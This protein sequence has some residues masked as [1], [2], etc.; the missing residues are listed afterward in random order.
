MA[1]KRKR[2]A[3]QPSTSAAPR[4]KL[5]RLAK[6]NNVTAAQ[7]EEIREAFSLYKVDHKDYADSAE[8]VLETKNVRHCLTALGVKIPRGE[9]PEVLETLDPEDEGVVGFENFFAFAAIH[10][11]RHHGEDSDENYGEE[12]ED[13]EQREEIDTAYE[14]FTHGQA[15]PITLGHLRTVAKLLKEDVDDSVLQ[16]MLSEANGGDWRR[17]V[18]KGEFEGVM[19]RAGVF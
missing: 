16:G 5:S 10:L 2:A 9:W 7:E 3:P 18:G 12:D 13:W 17:G 1:P 8:G 15:G 14:L 11:A 6:Q 19:R 4:P